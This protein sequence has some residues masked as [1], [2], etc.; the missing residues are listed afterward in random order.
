MG[1]ARARRGSFQGAVSVDLRSVSKT[2]LEV[3][4]WSPPSEF[5][6]VSS[7]LG[8]DLRVFPP[9][10]VRAFTPSHFPTFRPLD[11]SL[12]TAA[13]PPGPI[14]IP[15][16]LQLPSASASR[17]LRPPRR[18]PAPVFA[19]LSALLFVVFRFFRLQ[20]ATCDL[21]TSKQSLMLISPPGDPASRL[22]LLSSLSRLRLGCLL[23]HPPPCALGFA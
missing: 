15:T 21:P 9:S 2:R 4:S 23:V 1:S 22:S 17:C 13:P 6:K 10:Y 7:S 14:G 8:L 20:T 16:I 3:F 5:S 11:S 12:V 18:T 19:A